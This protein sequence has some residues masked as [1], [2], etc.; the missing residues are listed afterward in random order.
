MGSAIALDSDPGADSQQSCRLK[1]PGE[2]ARVET[3]DDFYPFAMVELL[4]PHFGVQGLF[5][6]IAGGVRL[7]GTYSAFQMI[8]LEIT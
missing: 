4:E 5:D 2:L 3:M 1:E 7:I 6:V 8:Y